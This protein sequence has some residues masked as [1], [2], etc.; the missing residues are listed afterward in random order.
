MFD[1]GG[2][3]SERKKW[4]HYLESVTTIIVCTVLSEY[5]QVLP[6][7]SK[8]VR[9]ICYPLPSFRYSDAMIDTADTEWPGPLSYSRALLILIG[10]SP[11]W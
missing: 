5:D 7:E 10:S 6:E 11:H 4:I 1:V 8:T 2:Q 3:R 9:P